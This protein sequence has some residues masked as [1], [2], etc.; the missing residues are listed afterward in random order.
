MKLYTEEQIRDEF[1]NHFSALLQ[2]GNK[3]QLDLMF[4]AFL[5][6]YINLKL[7]DG[8]VHQNQS[9]IQGESE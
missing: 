5:G 2:Y 8:G 6:A 1:N 4:T 7:V 3:D 9:P